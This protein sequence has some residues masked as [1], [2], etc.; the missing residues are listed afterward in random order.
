[1]AHINHQTDP[2]HLPNHLAAH[3]RQACIIVLVAPGRKQGLV[4][5]GQLHKAQAEPVK[6]LHQT[7]IILYAG[8]VLRTKENCCAACLPR[9]LDVFR[10]KALHD[11]A[12]KAFEPAVPSADIVNRLTEVLVVGYGHMNR[13][14]ATGT[15]LPEDFFRP[16]GVLQ[17]I[18]KHAHP[19]CPPWR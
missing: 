18:N 5:V 19:A 7:D 10:R 9:S 13:I 3:P 6:N 4:V 1:M 15:H 2:V 8:G 11:Q 12:R 17:P 16:V 14:E